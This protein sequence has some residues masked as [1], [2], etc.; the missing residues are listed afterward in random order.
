MC[1][2]R[3]QRCVCSP[4]RLH[5]YSRHTVARYLAA[6]E[7][8]GVDHD[9]AGDLVEQ[10]VW[11][12]AELLLLVDHLALSL[13]AA[14]TQRLERRETGRW[15]VGRRAARQH[16]DRLAH[17]ARLVGALVAHLQWTRGAHGN[18]H[19]V[20]TRRICL[21]GVAVAYHR[22]CKLVVD[23]EVRIGG[24]D[25]AQQLLRVEE[26]LVRVTHLEA[27]AFGACDARAVRV[28]RARACPCVCCACA[29]A[30]RVPCVCV[31]VCR[32]CTMFSR[33]MR[34]SLCTVHAAPTSWPRK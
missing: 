11:D 32:A 3:T 30:V 9:L 14:A 2:V 10:L 5:V 12:V 31:C 26:E 19:A 4:A 28:P 17:V 7:P 8:D 24:G 13:D 16:T 21:S 15:Q 27:R 25:L 22:L 18:G 34:S 1:N 29:C 33:C 20:H 6:G 23:G